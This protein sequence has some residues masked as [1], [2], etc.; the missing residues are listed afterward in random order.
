MVV[1][2]SGVPRLHE[3]SE[4]TRLLRRWR[5]GDQAAFDLLVPI[6]YDRLR[7]LA[8]QRVRRDP[9]TSLDTTGLVH[10]AYLELASS[11]RTTLRDRNHFLAFASRVM[12]NLLT[13]HT[14][15][16]CAAKRG[17]RSVTLALAE[18]TAWMPDEDLDAI[19]IL[20]E[21][22][23]RLETLDERQSQILEQRYFGGLSLE[24]TADALGISLA[25][26]KR[27]LRAA[28]AWLASALTA[29]SDPAVRDDVDSLLRADAEAD[30]RLAD[31]DRILLPHHP[32]APGTSRSGADPLGLAG[33]TVSHFRVIEPIAVGGMAVV[34]RAE[35]TRL[36][37]SVALKLPL[38]ERLG[39]EALERFLRECRVVGALDHPNVCTIHEVGES[40][41]G[42]LYLAMPLYAGETLA[43]RLART[44]RLGVKEAIAITR[45]IVSGVGAA[46]RAGIVHRDVKPAN[47]MLLADGS[48]KVLDFGLAKARDVSLTQS[49]DMF[50]TVAYM[51]PEQIRGAPAD[52]P[53]DLWAIGVVLYE[54]LTGRRPFTGDREIAVAYAVLHDEPQAPSALRSDVTPAVEALVHA[55]LEKDPDRRL[56]SASELEALLDSSEFAKVHP[57]S[58]RIRNAYRRVR[59][60]AAAGALLVVGTAAAAAYVAGWL[61]NGAIKSALASSSEAEV[62]LQYGR[63]YEQ[64]PITKENLQSAQSL[65]EQALSV[66][67]SY[68]RARARLAVTDALL[69]S[70]AFDRTP[71]RLE[72]ARAEANAAVRADSSLTDAH[73]ALGVVA[74]AAGDLDRA[75]S[76]YDVALRGDRKN[77]EVIAAV[78]DVFRLQGRWDKAATQFERAVAVKPR[79][80]GVLR[81]LARTQSRLRRYADAIRTWDQV[82]AVAPDDGDA[83]LT[84]AYAYIR[85]NGTTDTMAATLQRLAPDWDPE[86]S[87]T[88]ARFNL[89]RLRR[90]PGEALDAL[91]AS[92][93]AESFDDV[94]YRPRALLEGQAYADLGDTT[95]ARERYEAARVDLEKMLKA[96]TSAARVRLALALAYAG[97]G[98]NKEALAEA[99]RALN[100]STQEGAEAK[101]ATLVGIAEIRTRG[102]DIEGAVDIIERLLGMPAG[103]EVS[104]PLLRVDP[105]WDPLRRNARFARLLSS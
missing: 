74:A 36:G 102:G 55:L 97:L 45:A 70:Q 13:D 82:I 66:D 103:G 94:F 81:S 104:V 5:E 42:F 26:V 87:A 8:H 20:D 52:A 101:T 72:K 99:E 105:V 53:T 49:G 68:A 7:E 64:R 60:F 80:I 50:G 88:W 46:H 51:A 29:D 96:D 79:D 39:P 69:Y 59:R 61:G 78:G 90:R 62:F 2:V 35:D 95:R 33:R 27:E 6:I 28:Q 76:E 100:A 9:G 15:A 91:A 89:S 4:I 30:D 71:A 77:T 38:P 24:E 34:Y 75:L 56:S 86:G 11:E 1:V 41:D 54:M 18:E 57:V 37:R 32:A 14:R 65:Y 40:D 25:T 19:A 47:V 21:A 16:R 67:S 44:G 48:V 73:F 85:L 63:G 98:R 43:A 22:L 17:G 58:V 93:H 10:E 12:R 92:R 31:L 84:R 23:G 83:K 3:P